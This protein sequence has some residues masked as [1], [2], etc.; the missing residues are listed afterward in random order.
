[1]KKILIVDDDQESR[2]LLSEVLESNGYS[3][4]AVVDAADARV[5]LSR[6]HDGRIMVVDLNLPNESGLEF[7]R[8]LQKSDPAH[9]F[10]LMSSFLSAR[11]AQQARSLGVRASLTKP[12]KLNELLDAVAGVLNE[13]RA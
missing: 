8:T 12:F 6:D 9:D 3:V 11:D 2:D 10:I 1:M 13:N 4:A 7:I 5:E